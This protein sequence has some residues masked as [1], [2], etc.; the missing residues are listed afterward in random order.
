M[1]EAKLT[2]Q[3]ESIL[4]RRQE[5]LASE[6]S[7]NEMVM[8]NVERGFYYGV[9]DVAKYI[10][11]ALALPIS[12]ADICHGVVEHFVEVPQEACKEDTLQFVQDLMNE[13]LV[14]VHRTPP[15]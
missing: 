2:L 10:W 5:I 13:G 7:E 9:E 12:V 14:I 6:L 1:T 11:D 8:L 3:L 4:S 15:A